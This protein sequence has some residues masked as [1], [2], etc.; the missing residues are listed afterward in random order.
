MTRFQ[1]QCCIIFSS[2]I[3]CLT[4]CSNSSNTFSNRI[5]ELTIDAGNTTFTIFINGTK[6]GTNNVTVQTGIYKS[7]DGVIHDRCTKMD[8]TIT[9]N[10]ASQTSTSYSKKIVDGYMYLSDEVSTLNTAFIA[11]PISENSKFYG[12]FS[13]ISTENVH[14]NTVQFHEVYTNKLGHTFSNV[15]EAHNSNGLI[16]IFINQANFIIQK[17]DDRYEPTIQSLNPNI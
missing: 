6:V 16:R 5:S 17:E 14:L 12:P 2:L 7:F 13:A 3:L 9:I 15:M 8:E 4:G 1:Y 11:L 10:S